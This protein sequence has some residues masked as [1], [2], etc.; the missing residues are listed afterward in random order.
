MIRVPQYRR[1]V[2]NKLTG[3]LSLAEASGVGSGMLLRNGITAFGS[4]AESDSNAL[5]VKNLKSALVG[6]SPNA[7]QDACQTA[8]CM[9][10]GPTPGQR[11]AVA[12]APSEIHKWIAQV[13][14]DRHFGGIDPHV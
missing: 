5:F 9:R 14:F 2:Q 10:L 12:R 13:P 3:V 8:S 4:S 7:K 1:R 11:G 6:S